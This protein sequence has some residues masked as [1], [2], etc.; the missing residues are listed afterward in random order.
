MDGAGAA[1]VGRVRISVTGFT[2]GGSSSGKDSPDMYQLRVTRADGA[3]SVAGAT[4]WSECEALDEA[5][6]KEFGV[7]Y[8]IG[9]LP[10]KRISS[11]LTMNSRITPTKN[12][13]I[14]QLRGIFTQFS[15]RSG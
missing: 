7:R 6:K 10:R 5:L 15:D 12:E 3:I 11:A 2:R 13:Y 4:R 1:P 9:S 14:I 8:D